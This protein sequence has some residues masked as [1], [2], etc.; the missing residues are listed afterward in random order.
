M[1]RG[2]SA[3][4]TE[5]KCSRYCFCF[6][7]KTPDGTPKN[8]RL[9]HHQ[10]FYGCIND[11]QIDW[12]DL[13]MGCTWRAARRNCTTQFND[14]MHAVEQIHA[15]NAG[16]CRVTAV[17]VGNMSE[18]LKA[19]QCPAS[20]RDN[21]DLGSHHVLMCE[22]IQRHEPTSSQTEHL[23]VTTAAMK[24]WHVLKSECW[25][26]TAVQLSPTGVIGSYTGLVRAT[27]DT[28]LEK[29]AAQSLFTALACMH[30]VVP[31]PENVIAVSP[32]QTQ[33]PLRRIAEAIAHED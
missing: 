26:N 19:R 24:M 29:R 17:K 3:L 15:Q 22:R 2:R 32:P 20:K 28:K 4:P 27:F 10:F 8:P 18:F 33:A 1:D 16:F 25:Y 9:A 21:V 7:G 30:G 6:S 11:I 12:H 5:T 14:E 31:T 23:R 13:T